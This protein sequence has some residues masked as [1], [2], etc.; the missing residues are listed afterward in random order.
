MSGNFISSCLLNTKHFVFYSSQSFH[1]PSIPHH[2]NSWIIDTGVTDHMVGSITFFTSII[3]VVSSYVKL[4]NGQIVLVTHIGTVK[5]SDSLVLANVLC[6]PSFSFN[7]ISVS[8]L[9]KTINRCLIF[10]HKFCFL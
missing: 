7:L 4:I 10:I 1:T 8:K 6:V 9:I 3:V 5:L 2:K